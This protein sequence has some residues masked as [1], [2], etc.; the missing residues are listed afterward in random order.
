MKILMILLAAVVATVAEAVE[1]LSVSASQRYPW[2]NLVDV[3]MSISGTEPD[4]EYR[5]TLSATYPG[6]TAD[7]ECKTLLTEP[8]VK[9]DATHR[10]TWD[11]GADLPGVKI[12]GFV[13]TATVEPF[14]GEGAV[15]IVFDI[16]GGSAATSWP[17]RYTTGMPDVSND[18]CRTSELWMRRVPAGTFNMG[19]DLEGEE[20]P[21]DGANYASFLPK[22]NV[23]LTKP[24]YLGV[25][26]LTQ[27]QYNHIT[28]TWPSYFSNETHRATRPVE[29]VSFS[30]FRGV[31]GS[32]SNGNNGWYYD[33][34]AISS[35]SYL[36]MIRSKT[37]FG[38]FDLPTE[39]QWE[40]ACRAGKDGIYYFSDI[41]SSSISA[42]GRSKTGWE[43]DVG[44]GT[45][46][47]IGGTAKV[48]SYPPNPW[49]FYDMYGN[50]A[51][52]CGD[53]NP[54]PRPISAADPAAYKEIRI[55]PRC[56][57]EEA[58]YAGARTIRGGRWNRS[59]V[60]MNNGHRGQVAGSVSGG[61]DPSVGFRLCFTCE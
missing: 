57:P 1:I 25:F 35:D 22:H 26:E 21:F 34:T 12:P 18:V 15:Y 8:I 20:K 56:T 37:G 14:V 24:Y 40:R 17:H 19:L 53:G 43:V 10:I 7:V 61:P 13:V 39:A 4:A 16:S 44:E 51:E 45:A 52:V 42:Y 11:A 30:G 2:S 41:D 32:G 36:C 3:D 55:D 6:A 23:R 48:G 47:D 49:G 59:H 60:Y 31:P 46:P 27:A 58:D 38:T 29:K 5:V 54:Y 50:V 33:G 28:G 9:G